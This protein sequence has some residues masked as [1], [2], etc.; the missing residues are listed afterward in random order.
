MR[1]YR[2]VVFPVS[3]ADECYTDLK[4][5]D[6]RGHKSTTVSG[7][8]CQKWTSQTP[9]IPNYTPEKNPGTGLGDHNYC[10]NPDG[11]TQP[12]CYTT[13]SN[14]RWDFCDVGV[15]QGVCRKYVRNIGLHIFTVKIRFQNG[16]KITHFV[17]RVACSVHVDRGIP[18][19]W[20]VWGERI[21]TQTCIES[22]SDIGPY[23]TTVI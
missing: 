17:Y 20:W 21:A 6:Y 10:R 2:S 22:S 15:R 4:G 12:W 7:R 5:I 19:T 1:V 11:D 23:A 16:T 3:T 14:T 18:D 8:T 13:D 9:N